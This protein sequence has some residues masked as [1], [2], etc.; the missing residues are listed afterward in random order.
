LPGVAGL[1][2]LVASLPGFRKAAHQGPEQ[3]GTRFR[4]FDRRLAKH[5]PPVKTAFAGIGF[6]RVK[7]NHICLPQH[8][9]GC[10]G[11]PVS[12]LVLPRR[13]NEDQ[14]PEDRGRQQGHRHQDVT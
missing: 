6:E 12:Q 1:E 7:F 3:P 14:H 5:L 9:L 2:A 13:N 4:V 8:P 10:R 11:Q